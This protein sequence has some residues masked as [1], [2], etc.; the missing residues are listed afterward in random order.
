MELANGVIAKSGG[1]SPATSPAASD[2][3]LSAL[4]GRQA[5]R[6]G[7]VAYQ[8]RRVVLASLGLMQEQ[9]AERRRSRAL[10]LAAL[11]L[12]VLALGPFVWRLVEDLIAGELMGDI[13]TQLS[14]LSCLL[15]SALLAAVLVAGWQRRK[16]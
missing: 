11:L 1:A 4:A 7:A 14:L 9:K 15:C 5:A 12:V 2:D 13:P 6:D 10:A 16:Q 3:L 8:T